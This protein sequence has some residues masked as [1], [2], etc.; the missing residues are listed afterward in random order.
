MSQRVPPHDAQAEQ[1]VL[2]ALMVLP[3]LLSEVID[4]GL[5]ASDFYSPKWGTAFEAITQLGGRGEG[6]DVVTVNSALAATSG[7]RPSYE[8]LIEAV[9]NDA[10]SLVH[11]VSFARQVVECARLRRTIAAAFEVA[12]LGFEPEARADVNDYCDR[13]EAVIFAATGQGRT[14]SAPDDLGDL[15]D[16]AIDD[17]RAEAA[18]ERRGLSTGLIDVDR[19]L[20]GLRPDQLIVVAARPSIGKSALALGI[21]THT[22]RGGQTAMVFSVEMG[23]LELARRLLTGGG[24]DSERMASARLDEAD[25]ARLRRRRDQLAD[26]PLVIDDAP[27]MTLAHIRTRARREAA[28]RG[29]ALVVV[30]YLQLVMGD[31]AERRELEVAEISRGLKALARELSVPVLAVAQLNRAVELRTEKRPLLADLRD[32][33][34]IEQDAD[35]VV[36]LHRPSVYDLGADP[37]AAELIVAKHRNGPTGSIPLVW[38]SN[39]MAFA[40]AIG[41]DR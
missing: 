18:G 5:C 6:I 31:R 15:L 21:A 34:Q 32:S 10:P 33:G 41:A 11:T 25:F 38:L 35:V 24:V 13:A 23:R 12:Q 8:D 1:A 37:L 20:G 30:D 22:A 14:P 26:L 2:G 40:D 27:G 19:K 28:R 7:S 39:R 17:L 16:E 36:L 4:A 29:L 9:A 3:D